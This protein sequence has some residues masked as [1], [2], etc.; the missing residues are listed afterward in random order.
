M[1]DFHCHSV[2]SDGELIPAEIWRRVKVLNYTAIAITDHAD[3]SNFEFILENLLKI[4]ASFQG[5]TPK[6]LVGIEITHVPPELIPEL[7]KR[8]REKG[9]DLVVVHGETIV[10]P[11][12]EGTN[13]AAILGGADILAHP[14]L[15]REEEVKL[16]AEKGVFLE[17][18]GRKGHSLTNGHVVK[19]AKKFGAPLVINSD[20]HSPSD[21]LTKDLAL[22]IAL[23]AGL[24][25]EET[26]NL[27]KLAQ[28]RFLK[29]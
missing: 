28:K 6:M 2:F 18:S 16:A 12:A 13:R 1:F 7:I 5:L 25:L 27:W 4:K 21:F 24:T 9:A 22:K 11:V 20:A 23:G 10:E 3:P 15:I 29:I 26:E 19:L 17:I 8:A 14:G